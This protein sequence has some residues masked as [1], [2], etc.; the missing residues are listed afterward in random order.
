MENSVDIIRAKILDLISLNHKKSSA[1]RRLHEVTK[2]QTVDI[3]SSSLNS[4]LD[5]IK[6]KQDIMNSIDEIDKTFYDKF[7][8]LKLLLGI[9]SIEEIDLSEFPEV[10]ELKSS[11]QEIMLQ[12]GDIDKLDKQNL[13]EVNVEIVKLKNDMKQVQTQSRVIKNYGGASK[14]SAYGKDYQGFYI[15]SKK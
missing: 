6:E 10:S 2:L 12:L 5:H 1:L 8:E 7:V 11:V 4:L 14:V 15:D 13:N 9:K 3:S